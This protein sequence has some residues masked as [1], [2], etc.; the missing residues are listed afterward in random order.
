MC[1]RCAILDGVMTS[2]NKTVPFNTANALT[3]FRSSIH[4]KIR[5]RCVQEECKPT[6]PQLERSSQI[7]AP[8]LRVNACAA[9]VHVH[10]SFSGLKKFYTPAMTMSV[11][12]N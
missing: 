8:T 2:G 4:S 12:V 10:R 7:S 1:T 9:Q 11:P 5:T 6:D 3:A